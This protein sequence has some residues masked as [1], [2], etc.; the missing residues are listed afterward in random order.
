MVV[1]ASRDEANQY[2]AGETKN[3]SPSET[4]R[5]LENPI[6]FLSDRDFFAQ[7]DILNGVE[8]GDAF[9]HRALKRFATGN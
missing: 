5:G 2:L 9:L 8:K 4:E 1:D 3:L 7:V 6:T